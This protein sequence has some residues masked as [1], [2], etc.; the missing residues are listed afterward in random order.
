MQ[1]E[2]LKG[3]YTQSMDVKGR[4]AFPS[5]L[6][7]VIGESFILTKGVGGCIFVYSLE[8][9]AEKA[10]KL[11]SLPMATG[12]MLQR[13]FMANASDVEADKQGR[14]LV[15]ARLR[16]LAG[17]EKDVVVV[18]VSDHCE[19]WNPDRW[20]ELNAGVSEEDFMRALEGSDF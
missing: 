20:N 17:L 2:M 9:F 8:T 15:P 16:E 14:I 19:I 12:L 7:E 5:K 1:G 13:T 10:D 18:G 4:M 6:R 3:T 11:N